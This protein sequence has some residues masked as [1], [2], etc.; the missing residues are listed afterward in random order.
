MNLIKED[1]SITNGVIPKTA[2]AKSVMIGFDSMASEIR[3]TLENQIRIIEKNIKVEIE[4]LEHDRKCL[5]EERQ[6]L[7]SEIESMKKTEYYRIQMLEKKA[8]TDIIQSRKAIQREKQEMQRQLMEEKDDFQ[9]TQQEMANYWSMKEYD[10]AQEKA[11]IEQDKTKL[12]DIAISSQSSVQINVG[13]T[14]FE[15]SR[16]LLTEKMSKGSLLDRVYSG[17]TYNIEMKYDKNEN[18]FFDRDPEIFKTILRF[19]RDSSGLPPLPSD[20]QASLDLMKEM[21]YYGL[22]FYENSLVYVFGGTNGE[23]ILNTAELLVIRSHDDEDLCWSRTKSMNT[24]RMYSCA[25]I[26]E[27]SNCCVFGGYN[28]SNKVLG[29]MEIYDPLINSW[30]QGATLKTARR[31]MAGTNFHDGRIIAAGGFDGSKILKSVEIYDYRMRHW[32]Q[33]PSLNTARSS[34]SCVMLDDHRLVILGGTNGERLQSI[35]IFDVRRNKWDLLSSLELIDVRS[36]S[37]ACNIH[38]KIGIWGGIDPFHNIIDSGELVNIGYSKDHSSTYIKPFE[39]PLMDA[40][41]VEF[42]FKQ[43]SALATGGQSCD[44]TLIASYFYNAQQDMW[45]QGPNMNSARSG[46]SIIS[47]NI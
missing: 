29:C 4:R 26:I 25:A 39:V 12:I 47:L 40:Q 7:Y 17:Q 27:Q 14:I 45:T 5:D 18:I 10:L 46:H 44:S 23:D 8:E 28:S 22:R 1:E 37:I 35:E 31:N 41:I 13:G 36:G 38:G 19:L 42:K 30:R 21:S 20:P 43:Y 34:A 33:G 32:V 6:R 2:I 16:K 15:V 11:K 9:R 24:S 3:D